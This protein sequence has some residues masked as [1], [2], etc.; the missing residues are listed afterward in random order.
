MLDA[1]EKDASDIRSRIEKY[2]VPGPRYTSYP[3]APIWTDAISAVDYHGVL[4]ELR[5]QPPEGFA[6]YVHIPFCQSLCYYCGCNIQISH[7]HSRSASYVRALI[8]EITLLAQKLGDSP[9]SRPRIRQ[10]SW[11]GGTPTYLSTAEI[12]QLCDAIYRNF[13]LEPGAEVSIEVD[14]RVTTSEQL[15]VLRER[16]F[17]RVSLGV[18]DFNEDVQKAVNRIQTPA[19]TLATLVACRDLGFSGINFDLMYGLP[20]QTTDSFSETISR[21]IEMSPDRIALYNYAR[22]PSVIKHQEILEKYPMP[23]PPARISMFCQALSRFSQ[24][25]YAV[26]GMDHFAKRT[27]DLY[28]ALEQGTLYRNFMGYTVK[29]APVMLA[30]GASAIG[31]AGGVFFQNTRKAADYEKAVSAGQFAVFRGFRLSADDRIR[32]WTIQR[33][34]CAFELQFSEFHESFGKD[35]HDYFPQAKHALEGLEIDGLLEL[36]SQRI[37]VTEL[38]RLFVRNIAMQFDAYLNVS[39]KPFS[40]TV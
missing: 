28:R 21:V 27:D 10:M 30:V 19:L 4:E 38:G 6:L 13:D 2:S 12:H 25:E 16:G 3:T 17:N 29:R 36:S 32:Q 35:F 18:Q 11:G 22:L 34:M 1:V 23:E 14:P 26:V 37:H 5:S 33:L 8:A 40:K 31:E 9:S 7:D 15:S 39:P 24:S 20:L